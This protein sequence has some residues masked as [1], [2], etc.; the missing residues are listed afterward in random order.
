[1]AIPAPAGVKGG[2]GG[3]WVSKPQTLNVGQCN[4]AGDGERKVIGLVGK[5]LTFD[6]GGY[7]LKVGG[8]ASN[9]ESLGFRVR[10]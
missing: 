10:V 2:G 1:M 3:I 5:G 7:N 4:S 9:F 8:I 6:S